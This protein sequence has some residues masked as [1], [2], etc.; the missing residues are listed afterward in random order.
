MRR[1]LLAVLSIV[2]VPL[3]GGVANAQ[4][5]P[6]S[7]ERV[8]DIMFPVAGEVRYS[9]DYHSDRGGGT[10]IHQGTDIMGRKLQPLHAT[11]DGVICYINGIDEPMPSWG[12][13]ITLC[14]D[15]GLDYRYVHINNDNPGTDDGQGGPGWAYAPGIRKGLRVAR[16]EWLAYMGDS[17]NAEGTPP[18]LHFE[19]YD[20]DMVDPELQRE[21]YKQG[22]LNPYPSLRDAERRGDLPGGRQVSDDGVRRLAGRNRIETAVALSRERGQAATVIIVPADTHAEALVAAPLAG[23]IDAPVL[24]SPNAGL[25]YTV[26][27]EVQRLGAR[28]AYVVGRTDQL[29]RQVEADLADAGITAQA[30]LEAPDALSLSAVVAREMASYPVMAD[31]VDRV[32]LAVGESGDPSRA[33]PDALSASALAAELRTPILLTR[34]DE[35]PLAVADVLAEL[36]PDTV[37]VVGGTVAVSDAVARAAVEAA[38]SAELERLS[39]PDRYGTSVAIAGRAR[40]IGMAGTT[41]WLATGLNFPDALAAGPAAARN[42]VPLV[43]VHGTAPGGSPATEAW[44]RQEAD[45]LDGAVVVGGT[46]A[47]TDAVRA[48]IARLV[49]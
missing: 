7:Y 31:G 22:R 36:S 45:G 3:V 5:S 11:V 25:D 21:K 14:G 23:L 6:G 44:L 33:W 13:S 26:A 2:L 43:L 30:R 10:R 12:Y 32:F 37:S 40:G 9:N 19:I 35:L 16:G 34:T 24:L 48:E 18:H 41:A 42:D 17:G 4:T 46:E 49:R 8:V 38:G 20:R 15:D 27:A 28:N 1:T 29:A 39:G 47:V